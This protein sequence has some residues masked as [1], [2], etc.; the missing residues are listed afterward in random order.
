MDHVNGALCAGDFAVLMANFGE[1][2]T[3]GAAVKADCD[4]GKNALTTLT[5]S[6]TVSPPWKHFVPAG[7]SPAVEKAL[8]AKGHQN[9]QLNRDFDMVQCAMDVTNLR[10]SHPPDSRCGQRLLLAS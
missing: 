5:R 7:A 1:I 9:Q 6:E 4:F 2:A 8:K 3:V 10:P